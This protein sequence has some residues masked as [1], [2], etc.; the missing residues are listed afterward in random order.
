MDGAAFVKGLAIGFAIAAPVGPIGIL[1]IQRTLAYGRLSGLLTGLGAAT[2]D[3][4]YGGIAAFGL[5]ALSGF[6]VSQSYP[7]K[8]VGGIFLFYLAIRMLI[9]KS[10]EDA[11]AAHNDLVADYASTVFLTLTNP[12]TILSFVAIFAGLGLGSTDYG[13]SSATHMV[14][15][16]FGGSVL[17]W[18]ILSSG[19]SIVRHKVGP[20]TYKI[21]NVGSA[22]II[23]TFSMLAFASLS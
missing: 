7:L 13:F 6:L 5:T 8:I 9:S 15:G 16:V 19:V 4:F 21:I 22:L 2:A 23:L 20:R 14:A 10:G 18:I 17:W 3:A 12:V 1:C 11:K